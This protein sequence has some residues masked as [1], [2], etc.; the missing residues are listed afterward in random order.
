MIKKPN[1]TFLKLATLLLSSCYLMPSDPLPTA[2]LVSTET[3][4]PEF[5]L[6]PLHTSTIEPI[7]TPLP[8]PSPMPYTVQSGT[9]A[10]I[11]NFAHP[12]EGCNWLGAAGQVFGPDGLP[13]LNLIVSVKGKIGNTDIDVF[14]MTG[15]P[16]GDVYGPAGYEIQ[17]ADQSYLTHGS[18]TIQV[19]NLNADPMTDP[20]IFNTFS[21]CNEN[22]VII[23]FTAN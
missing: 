13:V 8:V 11:G 9:P 12:D 4:M 19:F 2:S 20:L 14:S 16:E 17:L 23:N 22:L 3:V 1:K 21:D 6:T 18:L 7:A 5:T 10:Y 15:M